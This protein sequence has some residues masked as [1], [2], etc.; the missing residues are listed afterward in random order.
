[1]NGNLQLMNENL[2]TNKEW[3]IAIDEL[4]LAIRELEFSCIDLKLLIELKLFIKCL[5][6]SR[7]I[8][9]IYRKQFHLF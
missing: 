1:M 8:Y 2:L 6:Y 5:N 3:Q 9:L 4:K 7:Y